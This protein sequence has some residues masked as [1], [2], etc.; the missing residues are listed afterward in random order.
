M[1]WVYP[2]DTLDL[3]RG[4]VHSMIYGWDTMCSRVAIS[5]WG[6]QMLIGANVTGGRLLLYRVELSFTSVRAIGKKIPQGRSPE[7]SAKG[8]SRTPTP[9]AGTGI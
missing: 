4:V 8:G 1:L 9:N 3:R 6:L 5:L 7:V 2:H